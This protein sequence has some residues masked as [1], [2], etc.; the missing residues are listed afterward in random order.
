MTMLHNGVSSVEN[1]W[2]KAIMIINSPT[3]MFP[4][5]QGNLPVP[6]MIKYFIFS[7]K[8]EKKRKE[9]VQIQHY[10]SQFEIKSGDGSSC[11]KEVLGHLLGMTM[12]VICTN[13]Q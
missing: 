9:R 13:M 12:A 2:M 7:K 8:R 3:A 4:N 5:I 6:L 10:G 1:L 11:L